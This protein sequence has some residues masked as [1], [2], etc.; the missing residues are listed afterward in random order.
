MTSPCPRCEELERLLNGVRDLLA[1]G[2]ETNTLEHFAG[3][4]AEWID[5]YDAAKA[6]DRAVSA[7]ALRQAGR[8]PTWST[9]SPGPT[10]GWMT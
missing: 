9:R 2:H 1:E 7:D 10:S 8:T 6:R 4:V 3:A 5:V